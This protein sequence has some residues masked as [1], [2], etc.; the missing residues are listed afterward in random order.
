M[1]FVYKHP[2]YWQKIQEETKG[3]G[4]FIR[5]SNLFID[6]EK[7]RPHTEEEMIK[8]EKING[9]LILIGADDDGLWEAGKYV[10]RMDERLKSRPH[11]CEYEAVAYKYGTHF[12]LP[13]G[14]LR[15]AM[16]VGLKFILRFMFKSAKEHPNECEETRKDIDRRLSKA[17]KEWKT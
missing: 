14:L 5:S 8:I 7:A 3:S 17:L 12:V 15:I 10:R 4:D 1:P 11:K 13:E 16:P 6:S 2:E 9:K